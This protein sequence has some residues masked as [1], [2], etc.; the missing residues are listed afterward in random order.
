M[1]VIASLLT[2]VALM[3]VDMCVQ[4]LHSHPTTHHPMYAPL[5]AKRLPAYVLKN[6]TP[7]HV[8]LATSAALMGVVKPACPYVTLYRPIR[9]SSGPTARS[10]RMMACSL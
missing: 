8:T 9:R 3:A 2:S 5:P 1:T 4:R 6:V 10:V 7:R